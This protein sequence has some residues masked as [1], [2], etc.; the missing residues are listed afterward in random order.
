LQSD[1]DGWHVRWLFAELNNELVT[2]ALEILHDDV[3]VNQRAHR[4]VADRQTV[5]RLAIADVKSLLSMV[6][7]L[8]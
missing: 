6:F 5:D 8:E 3:H 2:M 1:C 4:D 7:Y